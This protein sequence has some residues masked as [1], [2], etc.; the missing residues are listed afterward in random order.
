MNGPIDDVVTIRWRPM[1]DPPPA[2]RV[3]LTLAPDLDPPVAAAWYLPERRFWSFPTPDRERSTHWAELPPGPGAAPI[4][5]RSAGDAIH[6]AAARY[7]P[8]I[9]PGPD[10]PRPLPAEAATDVGPPVCL[11]CGDAMRPLGPS[12][13]PALYRYL[14]D[15]CCQVAHRANRVGPP[16]CPD[17]GAAMGRDDL[18]PTVRYRCPDCP[19]VY[20]QPYS[21][22]MDA[23]PLGRRCPNCGRP[24]G[25]DPARPGRRTCPACIGIHE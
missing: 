20:L 10:G 5:S 6:E 12:S 2:I 25:E 7:G 4:A 18:G 24:T 19:H 22:E 14:C 21:P 17:C 9:T 15:R 3:Y 23:S 1:S 16:P 8:S 11:R 13:D